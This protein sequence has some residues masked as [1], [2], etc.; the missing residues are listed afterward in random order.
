MKLLVL[1][2]FHGTF[3]AKLK[4][5]INEQKIALVVSNGDY[6]SFAYRTLWFNYCYGQDRELWEVLGK[7]KYKQLVTRDVAQGERALQALDALP[8]PVVT[9]F[10]NVD[11]ITSDSQDIAKPKGK[12]YWAWEW[13]DI[14]GLWMRSLK[15]VHRI[16][17]RSFVF[18][19]YVFIGAYG[20]TNPGKPLSKTFRASWMKLQRLFARFTGK[21]LIFV[22]HNVPFNTALDKISMKAHPA[23]RGKHYGS[24]LIRRVIQRYRPLMHIGGHIHEGRGKTLLGRTLCINPGSIHEGQYAIVELEGKKIT[25]KFY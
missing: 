22:S 24:K 10:G 12:R 1:G 15:N 19:K 14:V 3:P 4:R 5:I 16:D 13:R 2:D 6:C 18:G 11:H 9:V 17:Y 20:G 25:T 23:V 7:Q 21:H 8:V